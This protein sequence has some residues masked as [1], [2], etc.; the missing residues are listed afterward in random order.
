MTK[1]SHP[2][3][4]LIVLMEINRVHCL[5]IHHLRTSALFVIF[6]FPVL[7][8]RFRWKLLTCY[9]IELRLTLFIVSA[10]CLAK[11]ISRESVT[12]VNL[13]VSGG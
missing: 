3:H 12:L 4:G 1:L 8:P 2:L 7:S 10:F 6:K 13:I 9:L 11:T 5:K